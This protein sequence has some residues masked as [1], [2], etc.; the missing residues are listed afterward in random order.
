MYLKKE[1]ALHLEKHLDN[2][3]FWAKFHY[4]FISVTYIENLLDSRENTLKNISMKKS[5]VFYPQIKK[6]RI[7]F[8]NI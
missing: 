1:P 2:F 3:K 5:N 6:T 7:I 8:L 4:K